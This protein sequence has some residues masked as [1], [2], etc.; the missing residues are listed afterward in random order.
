[1][2]GRYLAIDAGE[3]VEHREIINEINERYKDTPLP[4]AMA[5]GEVFPTN[6]A[7]V[8][9]SGKEG[10]APALMKWGWPKRQGGGVIINARCETAA[11]KGMFA[12]PLMSRR[13]VV[14]AAGFF[15]WRGEHGKKQKY[16]FRPPE[17]RALYMA[18]LFDAYANAYVILTAPANAAVAPYHDRM[19]LI[20][21]PEA[22]CAWLGDAR[23]AFGC[24]RAPCKASLTAGRA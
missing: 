8:L 21:A 23:F 9:V 2:C 17:G 4:G 7:P 11:E 5:A 13:C 20:L 3:I 19:P 6:V 12:G 18:G 14:P 15:E 22:L 10:P 16:L 1:M 24:L